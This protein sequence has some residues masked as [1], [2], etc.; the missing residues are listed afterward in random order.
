MWEKTPLPT[1]I[2]NAPELRLGLELYFTAFLELM[3]SRTGAGDGPIAWTTIAEYAKANQFD[4]VQAEDLQYHIVRMDAAY[5]K[6]LR[7]KAP[8]P[9]AKSP[10]KK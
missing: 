9:A 2:A 4:E 1:K 3:T 5:L 7:S 6:W 8:Q 10:R